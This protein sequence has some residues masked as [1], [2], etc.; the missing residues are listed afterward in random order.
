MKYLRK[1]GRLS[2]TAYVVGSLAQIKPIL[3]V[4]EDGRAVIPAKVM[5]VRK[6]VRYLCERLAV[7]EMDQNYPLYIMYTHIQE[8]GELLANALAARDIH[9]PKDHLVGVGA[10]VGAHI[11]P[12][13]FG[14]VYVKKEQSED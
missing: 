5:G 3:H 2:D 7:Q 14:I 1:G 9:V 4:S 10:V 6:G 8:N 11:G 12:N 13:A